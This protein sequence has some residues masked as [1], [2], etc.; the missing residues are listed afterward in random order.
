MVILPSS[1]PIIM[2]L[3]SV[4]V[5]IYIKMLNNGVNSRNYYLLLLLTLIGM[6]LEVHY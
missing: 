3:K 6:S 5:C 4:C 1:I 2:F